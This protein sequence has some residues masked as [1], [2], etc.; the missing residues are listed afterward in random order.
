[1]DFSQSPSTISVEKKTKNKKQNRDEIRLLVDKIEIAFFLLIYYFTSLLN[2][3]KFLI[4][5]YHC[6]FSEWYAYNE[7]KID[8]RVEKNR[9]VGQKGN[10]LFKIKYRIISRKTNFSMAVSIF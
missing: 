3:I 5:H 7:I 9:T 6:Y 2:F 10:R 1:M 8:G 4:N